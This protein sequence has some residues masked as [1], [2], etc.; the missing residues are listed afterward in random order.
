MFD[1]S[2]R[3]KTPEE[4]DAFIATNKTRG[5]FMETL[6]VSPDLAGHVIK[7][8][9]NPKNRKIKQSKVAQWQKSFNDKQWRKTASFIHMG[10]DNLMVDGHHR[11][12]GL[13]SADE[14]AEITFIFNT[15]PEDYKF[16]DIGSTRTN[17]DRHDRPTWLI[18][19]ANDLIL[20]S[21]GR[22]YQKDFTFGENFL[23]SK[24]AQVW[25]RI[26]EKSRTKRPP[27]TS[28]SGKTAMLFAVADGRCTEEHAAFVFRAMTK[29]L[30]EEYKNYMHSFNRRVLNR[31]ITEKE[32]SPERYAEM[33]FLYEEKYV[34]RK[35]YG[36]G[37]SLK[38]YIEEV[39]AKIV[40][41]CYSVLDGKREA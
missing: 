1:A 32:R 16:I 6:K 22:D 23:K 29:N 31:G 34:D 41:W 11:F 9:G 24:D 36:R 15:D 18:G 39:N 4:F 38:E 14:A 5:V 3:V 13:A 21:Y 19:A 35:E 20:K 25:A 30:T 40:D 12:Y 37:I 7:K 33:V 8:Y 28:G 26:H 10:T 17:A 27:F 2:N